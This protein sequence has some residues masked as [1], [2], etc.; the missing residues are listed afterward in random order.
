MMKL[1][2]FDLDGTLLDT[3][4]DLAGA[5]EHT[6]EAHSLPGHSIPEYKRMIGRGMRNL[7]SRP[8]L[9]NVCRTISWTR[10]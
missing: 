4:G 1:I 9:P 3:A 6:L 8:C 7:V 10:S 5:L 2:I